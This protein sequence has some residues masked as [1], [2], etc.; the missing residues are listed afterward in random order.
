MLG[1]NASKETI[2]YAINVFDTLT[3]VLGLVYNR[4]ADDSDA[5]IDALIEER[6]KARAEKNWALADKIRDEL[7]AKGIVLEDTPMGVKWHR[8]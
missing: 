3:G 1:V 8:E 5:E 6:T 4:K 2:E 7:K